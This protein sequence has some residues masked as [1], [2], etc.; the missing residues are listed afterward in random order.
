V[1]KPY[2]KKKKPRILLVA[3]FFLIA[4]YSLL[5]C[6]RK[7]EGPKIIAIVGSYE[8]TDERVRQ[9]VAKLPGTPE[10][11]HAA[12]ITALN[13]IVDESLLLSEAQK[14]N[15]T[16]TDDEVE[17]RLGA[18]VED[19]PP[20]AFDNY[21]ANHGLTEKDVREQIKRSMLIAAALEALLTEKGDVG[22]AEVKDYYQG[23][24]SEFAKGDSVV[25]RRVTV[26][27]AEEVELVKQKLSFGE[28]FAAIA[29]A[30]SIDANAAQGGEMGEVEIA[31]LPE[32]DRAAIANLNPGGVSDPVSR[33]NGQYVFYLLEERKPARTLTLEEATPT[34]RNKL[35]LQKSQLAY[36]DIIEQLKSEY[37]VQIDEQNIPQNPKTN[38]N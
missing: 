21:L 18:L 23:N 26:A 34:I 29:R 4:A 5:S 20:G 14:H 37:K 6:G 30:N 27:S 38:E 15:L 7:E 12:A 24:T 9:E 36:P 3:M 17:K 22:E 8:I 25:L 16:V 19:Y 10:D 13:H 11:Y 35:A 1:N 32:A 28:D 31:K 2:L 33:A